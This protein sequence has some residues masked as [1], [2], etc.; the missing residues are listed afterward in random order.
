MMTES[1]KEMIRIDR[2]LVNGN[3]DK[4]QGSGLPGQETWMS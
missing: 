2:V 4:M 1:F 3:L